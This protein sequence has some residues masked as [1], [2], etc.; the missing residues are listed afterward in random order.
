VTAA[1]MLAAARASLGMMS[2]PNTITK[3]YAARHG[4]E[5]LKA[6]WCDQG[7]TYWARKSGNAA[8]VLPA[9]D[10]AYTVWHAQDGQKLGRWYAGTTANIKAYAKAG[11]IVFFDWEGRDAISGIDHV[12]VVEKNLGD[13]RLQTIEANT[14]DACKRR[15]RA[16]PVIAGF[17]NPDYSQED[18]MPLSKA[19]LAAVNK[20]VWATDNIDSSKWDPKNP[21]WQAQSILKDIALNVRNLNAKSD[22]QNATIEQLVA[23]LA[24]RDDAVDVEALMAR[25]EAAIEGISV[26]LD[27]PDA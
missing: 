19:D 25:I 10:R 5:F 7:I 24:S 9:G 23:A 8:A 14:G 13:G 22:A 1:S 2:R 17:W 18:D 4:S 21:T 15:V 6:A 16:A 12:G 3:D 26:R 11:A 20:A 27:V